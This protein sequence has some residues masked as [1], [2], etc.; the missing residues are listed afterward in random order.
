MNIAFDY[1]YGVAA[2]SGIGRY[3]NRLARTYP[4]V[5]AAEDRFSLFF[6]DF[7]RKFNPVESCPECMADSPFS[8]APAHLL[9]ARV[10]ERLWNVPI[11]RKACGIASRDADLVH[12]TAHASVPVTRKQKMVCTIH[13]MASCRTNRIP[14]WARNRSS[15]VNAKAIV[16]NAQRADAILA[17]STF[18]AEEIAQYLPDCMNKISVV[19]L[20]IDHEMYTPASA[21]SVAAMRKALRLDRPYL[22][23][24]GR[25]CYL[26]NQAFLAKVFD[27][28][29]T[30]DLELV[31]SGPPSTAYEGVVREIGQT[32]HSDR[33]RLLGRVE[34]A[35]LPALYSGAELFLTASRSEGFGFTPL[36]AMACGAPVVSSA[37]GSL[38]EVL[39]DA[40][41]VLHE[42]DVGLWRMEIENLLGDRQLRADRRAK[43]LEWASRFTWEATAQKTL[44]L[45]RH[46]CG[47]TT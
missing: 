37:A 30:N 43:G 2:V 36:E 39:G 42:E 18:G 46:A 40:A 32:K 12:I 8:F 45:Y 19:P 1:T 25:V 47:V 15:S 44:A 23:T 28:M 16:A 21:E 11:L 13:D 41:S 7:L 24:I 34:D 17:D 31:I 29:N 9:P 5:A 6:I 3:A 14:N 20:G 27:A 4:S 22:L 26:K 38:P 33:I 35:L 10:Y